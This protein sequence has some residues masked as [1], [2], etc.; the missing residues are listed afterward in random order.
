MRTPGSSGSFVFT[1]SAENRKQCADSSPC[2]ASQHPADPPA[3]KLWI[4]LKPLG[5]AGFL[6]SL[7]HSCELV[8]RQ[9][10]GWLPCGDRSPARHLPVAWRGA[11]CGLYPPLARPRGDGGLCC[12]FELGLRET[13]QSFMLLT[14]KAI[15]GKAGVTPDS[16]LSAFVC[17]P[18]VHRAPPGAGHGDCPRGLFSVTRASKQSHRTATFVVG[19]S[20]T[21]N[22]T[23]QAVWPRSH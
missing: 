13:M 9:S 12:P 10:G 3:F 18:H 22:K 4:K 19:V 11:P 21:D 16:L 8:D 20:N 14:P 2:P 5:A 17:C 23:I 15:P 1:E 7:R 6:P